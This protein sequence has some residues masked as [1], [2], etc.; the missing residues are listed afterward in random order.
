MC[1]FFHI[2]SDMLVEGDDMKKTIFSILIKVV[3]VV[4]LIWYIPN[5]QLNGSKFV[6]AGLQFTSNE[7]TV[8]LYNTHPTEEYIGSDVVLA[9]EKLQNSLIELGFNCDRQLEDLLAYRLEYD[10]DYSQCYTVSRLFIEEQ[11]MSF[12]YDLIIDVHRDA[13][14]KDLSTLSYNGLNYAKIL[15]VIGKQTDNYELTKKIS[16][17]LSDI[18]NSIVPG[19]SRG[20]YE[21]DS[22]YNQDISKNMI[23]LELGSYQNTSNEVDNTIEIFCEIIVEYFNTQ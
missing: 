17:E 4:S 22:H 5:K 11:L 6:E 10:I 23:L 16:I 19:I 20:I 1:L 9:T 8:F 7:K 12:D 14:S 3:I 15:F 13:I 18:A 2:I 21:K